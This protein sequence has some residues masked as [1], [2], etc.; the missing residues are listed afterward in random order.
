MHTK[1][2]RVLLSVIPLKIVETMHV[3]FA[4]SLDNSP[5]EIKFT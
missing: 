2:Y 3:T 1:G 4:E 5:S